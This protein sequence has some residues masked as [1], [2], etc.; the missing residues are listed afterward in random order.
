MWQTSSVVQVRGFSSAQERK[1]LYFL[2]QLIGPCPQDGHEDALP[3]TLQ[4]KQLS[5]ES[6]TAGP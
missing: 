6:C 5:Q 1:R 3:G 2:K 4:E